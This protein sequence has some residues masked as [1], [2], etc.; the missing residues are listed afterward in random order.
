MQKT[1]AN[2]D[3]VKALFEAGA[4][5]GYSK[6]KR[7]PTTA[8][9]VYATKN[10]VDILDLEKVSGLAENAM[11]FIKT[12]ASEGKQLLFVTGKKDVSSK[13]KDAAIKIDQPYVCGRWIGGTLT[14]FEQIQKRV[15]RLEDLR[16]QKEK[17]LLGKYTKKERLMIDREIDKLEER[18]GGITNMKKRPAAL[19]VIDSKFE[20]VAVAEANKNNIPIISI[21]SSDCDIS[22]VT[23]PIVAN[24]SSIQSIMYFVNEALAAY[25]E[26]TKTAKSE[27]ENKVVK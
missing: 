23:H 11:T 18:F 15:N 27:V 22:K 20:E 19:F 13:L 26:G 1:D 10:N 16:T 7:H 24:D 21:C 5:F 9:Y 17:G 8:K 6:S 4:H 14:N 3:T 2:P 25:E 12:I